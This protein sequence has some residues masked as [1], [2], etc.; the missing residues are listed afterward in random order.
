MSL[1]FGRAGSPGAYVIGVLLAME[2]P[3]PVAA[4]R[5]EE[6]PLPSYA[7]KPLPGKGDLF[8]RNAVVSVHSFGRSDAEAWTAADN[9]DAAILSMTHQDVVTLA[10]GHTAQ[11][12]TGPNQ[13][14]GWMPYEDPNI[15]HY[16]ARY[17]VA[18]RPT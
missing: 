2:S 9:A 5:D 3:L 15:K 1:N 8:S 11:A 14:P 13:P 18:M 16:V 7:V 6:T 12:S 10:D 17:D 4:D